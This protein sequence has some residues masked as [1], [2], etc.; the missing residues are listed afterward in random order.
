MDINKIANRIAMTRAEVDAY[1]ES[2]TGEEKE[3]WEKCKTQYPIDLQ[4]IITNLPKSNERILQ[5]LKAAQDINGGDLNEA[6]QAAHDLYNEI[7]TLVS[8]VHYW[9]K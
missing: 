3:K 9:Y 7:Q 8:K 6:S 5:H 4:K 1:Y 2:L